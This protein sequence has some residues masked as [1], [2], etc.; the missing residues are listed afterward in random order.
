VEAITVRPVLAPLF[1][2]D[3]QFYWARDGNSFPF[4]I[5]RSNPLD[6][7]DAARQARGAGFLL[8]RFLSSIYGSCQ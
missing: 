6:T 5:N 7:H 4:D 3:P 8:Q 2:T 1:R